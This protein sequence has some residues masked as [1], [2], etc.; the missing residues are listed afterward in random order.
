[1][2]AAG[3]P[4]YHGGAREL[5][6]PLTKLADSTKKRALAALAAAGIGI[7]AAA[8]SGLAPTALKIGTVQG[9][10]IAVAVTGIIVY[11]VVGLIWLVKQADYRAPVAIPTTA[12]GDFQFIAEPQG[13][14]RR[15]DL[16]AYTLA[17]D[18]LLK[19]RRRLGGRAG[20]GTPAEH[21]LAKAS[22]DRIQ[23]A[24]GGGLVALILFP[25][26]GAL[27]FSSIGV[28]FGLVAGLALAGA[29]GFWAVQQAR[30][31][32]Q[33]FP[34]HGPSTEVDERILTV[35]GGG[36]PFVLASELEQR[37]MALRSNGQPNRSKRSGW[38]HAAG[39]MG[40]AGRVEG[41]MLIETQPVPGAYHEPPV[42][43]SFLQRGTLMHVVAP[44][45][46]CITL[47]WL[48]GSIQILLALSGLALAWM[49]NA[50]LKAY[51]L[52]AERISWHST[53]VYVEMEGSVGKTEIRA[54]RGHTDSFESA[55]TVIRSDCQLR[56]YAA[57][58]WSQSAQ[59][60]GVRFIVGLERD[61]RAEQAAATMIEAIQEFEHQGVKIRGIDLETN[62][63]RETFQANV[64]AEGAKANSRQQPGPAILPPE[65]QPLVSLTSKAAPNQEWR[66]AK[67]R[68]LVCPTCEAVVEVLEGAAPACRQCGHGA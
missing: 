52:L 7:I 12:P 10:A 8:L 29:M 46:V 60:D 9:G 51:Q 39:T 24:A 25:L 13:A 65:K 50:D 21:Q 49:G 31:L 45:L 40:D 68:N 22:F 3:S 42:A 56:L 15:R 1:M 28:A 47:P 58:V 67:V 5:P 4:T 62:A 37:M 18:L 57:S 61:E 30:V 55:N 26:L 38:A 66:E 35:H 41:T 20:Y 33:I 32:K 34:A 53:I 14:L 64:L 11:A 63:I 43:A 17:P 16:P 23:Y 6:N 48:P 2:V 44:F 36:D 54:G 59:V 19:L 27:T